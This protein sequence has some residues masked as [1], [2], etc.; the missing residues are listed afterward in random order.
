MVVNVA[1]LVVILEA[2]K[3]FNKSPWHVDGCL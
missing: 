2:V 3:V 1:H